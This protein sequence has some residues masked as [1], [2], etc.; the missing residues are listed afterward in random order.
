M[1]EYFAKI[2]VIEKNFLEKMREKLESLGRNDLEEILDCMKNLYHIDQQN[3]CDSITELPFTLDKKSVT[4]D[5][6]GAEENATVITM[7]FNYHDNFH[8][9]DVERQCVYVFIC[10]SDG[11]YIKIFLD[12]GNPCSDFY[13]PDGYL[14]PDSGDSRLFCNKISTK[15]VIVKGRTKIDGGEFSEDLD[16]LCYSLKSK[17]LKY[18]DLLVVTE[19]ERSEYYPW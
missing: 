6:C 15:E 5:L 16:F 11:R 14:Y 19:K 4:V 2:A 10:L 3:L 1:D 8:G 7:F 18:S 12:D 9:V 13:S 17:K